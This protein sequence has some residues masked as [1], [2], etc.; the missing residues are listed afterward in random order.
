MVLLT[1][2]P[3]D[4][5]ALE[6]ACDDPASG[7][8]VTFVGRVRNHHAGRPVDH[9]DYEAFEPMAE[10]RLAAI[11]DEAGARW[12]LGRAA[13]A[14]RLG[15]LAI[16]EAAVAVVVAAGHRGEAFEACRWIMDRIKAEA[17]IWKH[18]TWS[19]GSAHWVG[20]EQP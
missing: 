4:I 15:R 16:G 20:A 13:V 19:D 2:Q 9:L 17:P 1:H 8:L 3:L 12:P 14:H 18:E 11:L 6:R 5:E 7:A 10:A